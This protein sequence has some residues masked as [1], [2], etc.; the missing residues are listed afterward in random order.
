VMT[1][2]NLT[3]TGGTLNVYNPRSGGGFSSVI[4]TVNI[5]AMGPQ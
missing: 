1:L 5:I 2:T 3:A 4:F